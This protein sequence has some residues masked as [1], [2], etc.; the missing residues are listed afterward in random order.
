[1][2]RGAEIYKMG[3]HMIVDTVLDGSFKGRKQIGSTGC[4]E[5]GRWDASIRKGDGMCIELA[6]RWGN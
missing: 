2:L 1:M 4:C 5:E 6:E 3:A